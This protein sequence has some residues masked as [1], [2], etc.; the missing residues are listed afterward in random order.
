MLG[1]PLMRDGE[2]VGVISMSRRTVRPFSDLQ[3][4]LLTTFADQ[5]VIAIENVRLF[6][7]EQQRT[8]ELREA[9][10]QQT[11]TSKV[12]DVI[13]RSAFNL[14][15][16]FETVIES[17]VRLCG[18]DKAFIHR[19]DDGWLRMAASFNASPELREFIARNPMR[20]GRQS[21]SGSRRTGAAHDLHS[22]RTDRSG[23]FICGEKHRSG[24][25]RARRPDP[26]G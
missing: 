18:A 19:F 5:A 16:V 11:A 4:E 2:P 9:L 23:I 3:I 17:S 21:R 20:P 7:A 22:R 14:E 6:E 25:D 10:Q 26:Q 15:Q 8:L 12:L 13:S 1:V 24:P